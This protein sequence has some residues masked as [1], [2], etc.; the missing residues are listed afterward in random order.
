VNGSPVT[1]AYYRG[2]YRVALIASEEGA[3][4]KFSTVLF[5]VLLNGTHATIKHPAKRIPHALHED[6]LIE[7]GNHGPIPTPKVQVV[8]NQYLERNN[9]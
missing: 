6:G 8:V 7:S 5:K 2:G 3:I 4:R 1:V 9:E